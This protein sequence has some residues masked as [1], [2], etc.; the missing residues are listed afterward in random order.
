LRFAPETVTDDLTLPV[1]QLQRIRPLRHQ[2]QQIHLVDGAIVP[3]NSTCA[4]A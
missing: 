1:L 4:Q 2:H 3:W